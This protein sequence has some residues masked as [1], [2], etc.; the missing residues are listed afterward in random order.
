MHETNVFSTA[1]K[2]KIILA[3]NWTK[4]KNFKY[5]KN[6][7]QQKKVHCKIQ[8]PST[9]SILLAFCCTYLKK[10]ERIL[11]F[12][13]EKSLHCNSYICNKRL[14]KT[15]QIFM[16]RLLIKANEKYFFLIKLQSSKVISSLE[17]KSRKM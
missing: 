10:L 13:F 15:L 1:S 14:P 7:G 12:S 11:S 2:S 16:S 6:D 3:S 4:S 17:K 5:R 8:S 9:G